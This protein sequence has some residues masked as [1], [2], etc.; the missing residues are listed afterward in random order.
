MGIHVRRKGNVFGRVCMI[1]CRGSRGSLSH[2]ALEAY[3][4]I[5]WDRIPFTQGIIGWGLG[6]VLPK[7]GPDQEG[8]DQ[9]RRTSQE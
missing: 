7:E 9:G 2:D 1:T 6:P 3:P 8:L 4:M 5:Q